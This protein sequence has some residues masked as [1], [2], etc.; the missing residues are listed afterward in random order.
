MTSTLTPPNDNEL[1]GAIHK[2][3]N[4]SDWQSTNQA[5]LWQA[6]ALACDLDPQN[7]QQRG[8]PKFAPLFKNPPREFEDLLRDAKRSIV[9]NKILKVVSMTDPEPEE[10]EIKLSSF[11]A[12]LKSIGH[13][14]PNEFPWKT[15]GES[16][17]NVNWPWGRH[18]TDL[19]RKLAGAA[20]RFWGNYDP[21]DPTTA[22]VSPQVIDWLKG[23]GVS[24]N[25][26]QAMATILRADGLPTRTKK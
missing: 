21:G 19:L 9:A 17:I 18:E 1:F 12:W 11:A 23:Q 5:R 14:P 3:P 15:V 24:A 2:K 7:Y 25:I 10:C 4:W 6:V 20:E 13:Q 8:S 22:P 26:A 16:F